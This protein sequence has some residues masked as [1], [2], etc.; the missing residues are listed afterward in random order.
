MYCMQQLIYAG[1][2][3]E[4]PMVPLWTTKTTEALQEVRKVKSNC[5]IK[6][7]TPE[8]IQKLF[9]I[10]NDFTPKKEVNDLVPCNADDCWLCFIIGSNQEWE[11]KLGS[12]CGILLLMTFLSQQEWV[13]DR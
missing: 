12:F 1:W 8:E 2:A 3:E 5:M 6:G 7:K 11:R 13:E 9:N 4:H 10:V